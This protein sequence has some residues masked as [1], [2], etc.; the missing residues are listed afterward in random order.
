MIRLV[1]YYFLKNELFNFLEHEVPNNRIAVK[2][3]ACKDEGDIK[4]SDHT[5]DAFLKVQSK[6]ELTFS[7]NEFINRPKTTNEN[8]AEVDNVTNALEEERVLENETKGSKLKFFVLL[9]T[10]AILRLI[11]ESSMNVLVFKQV[12]FY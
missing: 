11:L 9:V 4:S 5:S 3:D 6:A 2:T 7:S 8:V 12:T 1:I 10:G